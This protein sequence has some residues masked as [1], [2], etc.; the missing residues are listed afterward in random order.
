MMRS[1]RALLLSLVPEVDPGCMCVCPGEKVSQECLIQSQWFLSS[2]N[3]VSRAMLAMMVGRVS[4]YIRAD[5]E[6][7]M[8]GHSKQHTS[9][10][11]RKAMNFPSS[12]RDEY[13]F[14]NT[15]KCSW[16]MIP[17]FTNLQKLNTKPQRKKSPASLYPIPTYPVLHPIQRLQPPPSRPIF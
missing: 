7:I 1:K 12:D 3:H 5:L 2:H 10:T 4:S 13:Q 6:S 16:Y 15:V 11:G 14:K 8:K 9:T 17:P